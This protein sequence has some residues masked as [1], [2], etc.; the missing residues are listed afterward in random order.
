[1]KIESM[2]RLS[3]D[4]PEQAQPKHERLKGY[5]LTEL[6][7]GRLKAGQALPSE[8]QFA[9]MFD[10]A[11]STV[12]QALASMEKDGLVRR[13]RGRGTFV[14]EL[15]HRRL[16]CG[17][18]A[19]AIITPDTRAGYYPSLLHGFERT[20]K[21]VGNQVFICNTENDI[22]KQAGAIL[23][24]IDKEVAGVAIVPATNPPTPLSQIRQLQKQGIPVVFCH[25][26]VQGIQAPLLSIPFC[27]VGRTAG[28]TF[29][30]H[31]HRRVAM[32]AYY[33]SEACIAYEAGLREAMCDGGGELPEQFVYCGGSPTTNIAEQEE[34]VFESLQEMCQG[35][36]PPT[37]IMC[38]FDD[39]AE[40]IYFQLDRLGLRVPED[41]SLMGFGGT[42][43][44]GAFA[45]RLTSVVV[46]ETELGRCAAK[47]LHEIRSGRRPIDDKEEVVMPL[48]LNDGKTVGRVP[49][50]N[51][52]L[53]RPGQ[54]SSTPKQQNE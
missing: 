42:W 40:M 28:R 23:D 15:A 16:R 14:D 52:R 5:L 39:L 11:R 37:A 19:F 24:L 10:V 29:I 6:T 17:I 21:E 44:R 35:P 30:E 43:R 31:G 33:R 45:Q 32:F 51:E 41:I 12:R 13:E 47:L 25:R 50:V 46:D 4:G 18:D 3:L 38:H 26:R 36:N 8:V 7:A 48:T 1:M 27:E 49:C 20:S 34:A 54:F 9:E 22:D 53:D 2:R